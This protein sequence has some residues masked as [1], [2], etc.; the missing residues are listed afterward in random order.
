MSMK[1]RFL[2]IG[3]VMRRQGE[4]RLKS[5]FLEQIKEKT[6]ETL[7]TSDTVIL[8]GATPFAKNMFALRDRLF[9]CKMVL[10][11]DGREEL[12]QNIGGEVSAV[13][14]SRPNA[15]QHLEW[16]HNWNT[17]AS[18]LQ[19]QAVLAC[20]PELS[21]EPYAYQYEKIEKQIEDIVRNWETYETILANLEDEIS[22]DI[23]MR[24]IVYRLTYDPAMHEG[25]KT[26][27]PHYFDEDI[28]TVTA[29]EIFID[30]GGYN[31]DTLREF[32]RI[33]KD[34][35]HKYYLFEPDSGLIEEAKRSAEA[36]DRF[37]FVNKGVWSEDTVLR[38]RAESSAGNGTVVM[39]NRSDN[40]VE[41]PVTTIDHV[42][43]SGT[44]IK[45][46]V[47]G[48]ELEALHGAESLI[49]RCMPRMAICVYHK[50]ED[51]R[52]LFDCIRGMGDYHFHLRAQYDNIDME[53]YYLCIPG[54]ESRNIPENT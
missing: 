32:R 28:V 9:P 10:L 7:E 45:M 27:Y 50:Y 47:E 31:G 1:D 11:A 25:I 17:N 37:T 41:V 39:E 46:D 21:M 22:K 40:V 3:Q 44:F 5:H 26:G 38:F 29:D 43:D 19:Y 30:C 18:I 33:S 54:K 35:F 13:L 24:M 8:V 14:C 6:R 34:R 12:P 52:E 53:L 23:F 42:T 48:S 51:Y 4:E 15:G 49:K 36:D 20:Y 2:E 16:L